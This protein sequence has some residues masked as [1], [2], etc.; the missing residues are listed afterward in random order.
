MCLLAPSHIACVFGLCTFPFTNHKAGSAIVVLETLQIQ[1]LRVPSGNSEFYIV[2]Y[3][4]CPWDGMPKLHA[5]AAAQLLGVT[6]QTALWEVFSRSCTLIGCLIC[7]CE[8]PHQAQPVPS[9]DSHAKSETILIMY[10]LI[11]LRQCNSQR[12]M[13]HMVWYILLLLHMVC[14][15]RSHQYL[16]GEEEVLHGDQATTWQTDRRNER[17]QQTRHGDCPNPHFKKR[18]GSATKT[19][20]CMPGQRVQQRPITASKGYVSSTKRTMSGSMP[21]AARSRTSL[22]Q[23]SCHAGR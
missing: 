21:I 6:A 18:K 17:V 16:R 7:H 8:T 23:L 4:H 22:R 15:G 5:L 2:G 13:S 14:R 11:H 19:I 12:G 3:T 1:K 20:A 10:R 9:W